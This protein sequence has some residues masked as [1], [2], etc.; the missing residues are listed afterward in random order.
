MKGS[1]KLLK[2]KG[3]TIKMHWSFL[4]ILVWIIAANA[5]EG[6]TLHN[7][8]WSLIFVALILLSVIIYELAHYWVAK[9]MGAQATE[10]NLLTVGGIQTIES[11]LGNKKPEIMISIA[12][13]FANLAM[14]D[15]FYLLFKI[16][17]PSGKLPII[18]M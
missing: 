4:I 12:G 18:L 15:C 1:I 13:P 11:F 17:Y 16:G 6:L 2:I 14:P 3:I 8:Q 10:I 7:I 5:V 9:K